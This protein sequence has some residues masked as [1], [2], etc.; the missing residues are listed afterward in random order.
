NRFTAFRSANGLDWIEMGVTNLEFSETVYFGISQ[1]QHSGTKGYAAYTNYG[2]FFYTGTEIAITESPQ[3]AIGTLGWDYTFEVDYT[4]TTA[5]KPLAVG[6][7]TFQWLKNG[8]AIEGANDPIY[9]TPGVLTTND[10][11][12]RYSVTVSMGDLAV[13]SGE[14]VLS[15]AKDNTPPKVAEASAT[16]PSASSGGGGAALH[17]KGGGQY[18]SVPMDIPETD[19]TVE[20]WFRTEDP[21]AGLYCVVDQNLGAGGH[22]RHLHLVDGN[23]RI[24]TWSGDGIAISSGLNLADGQWHHLAHVLGAD[25]EGQKIYIDGEVVIEQVKDFSNFDWQKH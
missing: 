13:T 17:F 3:S 8:Q 9:T 20:F 19:Y 15:V 7:L 21:N 16:K 1:A 2:P 24:R 6:E 11:G 18:V 4:A 22:D 25:A 23:I 5:G 10:D 14:A 12:S